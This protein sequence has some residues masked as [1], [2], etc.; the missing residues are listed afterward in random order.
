MK[1]FIARGGGL[2]DKD[3]KFEDKPIL[4]QLWGFTI[5]VL[6]RA[7]LCNFVRILIHRSIVYTHVCATQTFHSGFFFAVACLFNFPTMRYI[8][9]PLKY[10]HEG[11]V[12]VHFYVR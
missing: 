7:F 12:S 3:N 10:F 2:H 6:R 9:P 8:I 1:L 5:R 11:L 4:T